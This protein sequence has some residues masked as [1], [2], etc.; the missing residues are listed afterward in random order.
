MSLAFINAKARDRK[1]GLTQLHADISDWVLR[2]AACPGRTA[3]SS[4]SIIN[5][6]LGFSSAGDRRTLAYL[7]WLNRFSEAAGLDRRKRIRR[8]S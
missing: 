8:L 1:R 6:A 2:D 5:G 3:R 7:Q 4:K